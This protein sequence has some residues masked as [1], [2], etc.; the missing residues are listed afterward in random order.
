M[1]EDEKRCGGTQIERQ[2]GTRSTVHKASDWV[3][4][5][6]TKLSHGSIFNHYDAGR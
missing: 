2:V 6:R 3:Q 4:M 5:A 1:K